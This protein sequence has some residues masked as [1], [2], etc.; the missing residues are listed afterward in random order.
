M[1]EVEIAH[2]CVYVCVRTSTIMYV[3]ACT[4]E[5]VRLCTLMCMCVGGGKWGGRG[6]REGVIYT[7]GNVHFQ[8]DVRS[9]KVSDLY[10]RTHRQVL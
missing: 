1:C 2:M 3:H 7:R 9:C 6:E 5:C 4:C 10:V 8:K